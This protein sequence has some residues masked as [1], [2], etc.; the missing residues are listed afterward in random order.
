VVAIH[1]R[2]Y[3][4]PKAQGS[5]RMRK[6][7]KTR[8][9]FLAPDNPEMYG[10]R[11]TIALAAVN[12]RPEGFKLLDEAISVTAH[13]YFP[14]P[15]KPRSE[16]PIGPPDTDKLARAVGDALKGILWVD[17]SRIVSLEAHKFYGDPARVEVVV[18]TMES[19]DAGTD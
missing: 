16:Y 15:K 14:K 5:M 2:A 7:K 18:R 1:F 9:L 6:S 8:K 12:E 3:G 19:V 13:F 17:D 11:Q 10:W 4:M